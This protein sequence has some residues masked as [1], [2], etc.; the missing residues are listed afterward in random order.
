[1]FD[2]DRQ[3]ND[4][5]RITSVERQPKNKSRYNIHINE[6]YAFSVHEDIL[7]KHRILKGELVEEDRLA[8]IIKEDERQSAYLQAIR[9]ISH[10]PR[11]AK[12]LSLKLKEKGYESDCIEHAIERMRQLN[13]VN[14]QVFAVHVTE[15]RVYSQNKGRRLVQQELAQKGVPKE[16]I[17]EALGKLDE[18]RELESL[19]ELG[20]KRWRQQSGTP[21]EKKR[22]LWAFLMRRGFTSSQIQLVMKD[23]VGSDM[24]EDG[25]E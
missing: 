10:R 2:Q 8:D 15:Q 23:C 25:F 5:M 22:K 24:D 9:F 20:R 1:M 11:S 14:D 4:E 18:E 17:I 19:L 13:Y 3:H 21:I 7:I 6:V 16:D 12:E